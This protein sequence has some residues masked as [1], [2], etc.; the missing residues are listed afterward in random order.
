[1][2]ICR[3]IE[4]GEHILETTEKLAGRVLQ[5]RA[6]GKLVFLELI[7][8]GHKVQVKKHSFGLLSPTVQVI[9]SQVSTAHSPGGMHTHVTLCF[10]EHLTVRADVR[11]WLPRTTSL[12]PKLF[13]TKFEPS[14]LPRME[15]HRKADGA[16]DAEH[17]ISR[18]LSFHSPS[19]SSAISPSNASSVER[20]SKHHIAERSHIQTPH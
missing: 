6:Q 9:S 15:N 3:W 11:S 20:C 12:L 1:M 8:S 19:L 2:C 5:K 17:D 7:Q 16:S 13:G 18:S 10:S 14:L 4:D